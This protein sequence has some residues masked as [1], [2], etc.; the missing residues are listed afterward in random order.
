MILSRT[1]L[2][3]ALSVAAM[4]A[5]SAQDAT[6]PPKAEPVPEEGAPGPAAAPADPKGAPKAE[7]VPEDGPPME[8]EP[9]DA[10]WAGDKEARAEYERKKLEASK[11]AEEKAHE[12][13]A[14]KKKGKKKK[15]E[16]EESTEEE[17]KEVKAV[18]NDKPKA[19]PPVAPHEIKPE[20]PK[21][22]LV[23]KTDPNAKPLSLRVPA[24]RGLI[25]DRNG[26]PLA[27]NKMA[28][29]IGVQLPMKEGLTDVQILDFARG[30]MAFCQAQLPG[31]WDVSDAEIIQH[32]HKR[33][34]VPLMCS[35]LLP[36]ERAVKLKD[37]V[38]PGVILRPFFLR[39]YPENSLAGHLLGTMGKSGPFTPSK[40]DLEAD[41]T[42][43]PPT[44][45]RSGLEKRFEKELTGEPGHY[46][47]LFDSKGDMLSEEWR[48]RPRA[49]STIV[50]TLDIELQKI[51]ER[52]LKERGFRGAF[53]ILDVKT[54]DILAMA[55]TPCINPND[56]VYGVGEDFLKKQLK[57]PD[58]VMTCRAIQGHYPPASTFK[59]VTALAALETDAVGPD[60]EF[61]CPS[62]MY[63]NGRAM[64]NHSRHDEGMMDV[65]RAIMRSCNT[66]FFQAA[67]ACGGSALS[68]MGTRLGF[69]Q[70]TGICL[71][72]MESSG[73]MPYTAPG[74]G[75][76]TGG[77]LAN[78]SI[79]QGQV[80]ATPLQVAQMMAGVARGDAVPRPRL[81]KMIQDVDGR[82]IQH[83][84]TVLHPPLELSKENL[85]AVRRGMRA[86][87]AGGG[88]TGSRAENNYVAIA[89]KTGTGQWHVKIQ[90]NVAW[91]AGFIPYKEP[92]YAYACLYEGDPGETEISGGRK[93]AP[94]VGDV[95]NEIYKAKKKR[96]EIKDGSNE[97]DD[98]PKVTTSRPRRAEPV[99]EVRPA[100]PPPEPPK[101]GGLRWLFSRRPKAPEAPPPAPMPSG[102]PR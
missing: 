16:A 91:F 37:S 12:A 51:A 77:I 64:H 53:I 62:V 46:E 102:R 2:I 5:L 7:V 52:N 31:G 72:E 47:A 79:G 74:G 11:T 42:M 100:P 70:K 15:K 39:T 34:W 36:E 94:V 14:E 33:R 50:T 30:P 38:P 55:S 43:W 61:S 20:K 96:G 75:A 18:P 19:V 41:E 3:A 84:P 93:V 67:K 90:Q 98:G 78:T 28:H 63:F 13:E 40:L 88:G 85:N 65:E 44:V 99:E 35:A 9:P 80:E 58:L 95:F 25:V 57:E 32:Y 24:P 59:V 21:T 81:V 101:R 83:F 86:V 60:T 54:G 48:A 6:R 4:A 49:G 17:V 29:Y 92:E 76:I 26:L 45:G 1:R 8:D 69:G 68:T 71:E 27:Q 82:V 97:D 87:V 56:W 22:A 66:W 73:N 10:P 23:T 89:G